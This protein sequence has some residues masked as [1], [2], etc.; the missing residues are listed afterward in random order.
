MQGHTF[1]LKSTKSG[2]HWKQN[3]ELR[4]G[5]LRLG[6]RAF[7]CRAPWK[8]HHLWKEPAWKV[9]WPSGGM[10]LTTWPGRLS[11]PLPWFPMVGTVLGYRDP[12]SEKKHVSLPAFRSAAWRWPS[13]VSFLWGWP[14]WDK[15]ALPKVTTFPRGRAHPVTEQRGAR[16]NSRPPTPVQADSEGTASFAAL[17]G[18]IWSLCLHWSASCAPSPAEVVMSPSFPHPLSSVSESASWGT[19]NTPHPMLDLEGPQAVVNKGGGEKMPPSHTSGFQGGGVR[20]RGG[21]VRG[22]FQLYAHLKLH[23]S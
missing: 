12:S 13:P 18:T 1:L 23:D 17:Q 9:K 7:W 19:C 6:G 10:D 2:L 11:F 5:M 15:P 16:V 3:L 14:L 22:T 20:G 4:A 21:R 8:I